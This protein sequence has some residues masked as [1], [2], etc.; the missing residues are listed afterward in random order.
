MKFVYIRLVFI[1]LFV[2]N[3][4]I[5]FQWQGM[6]SCL[7]LGCTALVAQ[8]TWDGWGATGCAAASN[9]YA[10]Q[11]A[12]FALEMC[13][14]PDT[15]SKLEEQFGYECLSMIVGSKALISGEEIT[16]ERCK[17]ME[18]M[19]ECIE[20]TSWA[21]EGYYADIVFYGRINDLASYIDEL[22]RRAEEEYYAGGDDD[23]SGSG[24]GSGSG[25]GGG[26]DSSDPK[27]KC[28]CC[29]QTPCFC[30]K[31][32]VCYGIKNIRGPYCPPCTC[33]CPQECIMV[34]MDNRTSRG[35]Y[36]PETFVMV[37]DGSDR[38][39]VI[40]LF[41][42][43]PNT[44]SAKVLPGY[45]KI[46]GSGIVNGGYKGSTSTTY[47]VDWGP[48][49]QNFTGHIR[50]VPESKRSLTYKIREVKD[51]I[52]DLGQAVKKGMKAFGEP[53]KSVSVWTASVT[54]Q[55]IEK[56]V[57]MYA[58]GTRTGKYYGLSVDGSVSCTLPE[59]K[60]Y[61]CNYGVAKIYGFLNLGTA[62]CGLSLEAVKDPSMQSEYSCNGKLSLV[63]KDPALG[64]KGIVG[65]EDKICTIITAQA[66]LS[67]FEISNGFTIETNGLYHT[68]KIIYSDVVGEIKVEGDFFNKFKCEIWQT[69]TVFIKDGTN[70]LGKELLFSFNN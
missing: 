8:T 7:T 3:I 16:D 39:A 59:L 18:A 67:K 52:D 47:T 11:E 34:I 69:T 36:T 9:R 15:H 44:A 2:S 31:C 54:G 35:V 19:E 4:G 13:V 40:Y 28:N 37:S 48:G 5:S 32:N 38:E 25:D 66:T 29:K 57:D 63:F 30:D 65:I 33:H 22:C 20:E 58:D 24:S 56:N 55:A 41:P 60:I 10:L 42:N 62:S 61:V 14:F 51:R 49:C 17:E 21:S 50:I 23:G 1:L 45:P 26:G 70:P 6:K 68:P 43:F 46:T 53:T 12:Q 64:V 27:E